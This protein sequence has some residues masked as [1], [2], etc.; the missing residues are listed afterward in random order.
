MR[1]GNTVTMD[2]YVSFEMYKCC[3]VLLWDFRGISSIHDI[4]DNQTW[5]KTQFWCQR[6]VQ[7]QTHNATRTHVSTRLMFCTLK[8]KI[9]RCL[10]PVFCGF[11]TKLFRHIYNWYMSPACCVDG[12]SMTKHVRPISTEKRYWDLQSARCCTCTLFPFLM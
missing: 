9:R 3:A 1:F 7:D 11:Y 10:C 4:T 2:Y 6:F 5:Q 8:P 12:M